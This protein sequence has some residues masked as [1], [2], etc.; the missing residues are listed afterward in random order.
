MQDFINF[1]LDN[2]Q[3]VSTSAVSVI[4]FILLLI[5]RRKVCIGVDK[6]SL[7]EDVIAGVKLAEERWP[8][9]NGGK[10]HQFVRDWIKE[11]RGWFFYDVMESTIDT[12]IEQ[13]LSCPQKKRV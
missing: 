6:Q 3:F 10:K 13:V 11:K 8:E 2:W 12:Y 4:S 7:Y 5:F 9:G 1:I